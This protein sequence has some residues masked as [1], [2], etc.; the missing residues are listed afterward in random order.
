MDSHPHHAYPKLLTCVVPSG[1]ATS[2][3]DALFH[4]LGVRTANVHRGR[5][6]SHRS[7][8]FADE[9]EILTV[10]VPAD[11]ADRVFEFIYAQAAIGE[12]PHRFLFQA[13]LDLATVFLLPD[14]VDEEAG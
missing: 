4:Q 2:I 13:P 14:A 9:V 3:V 10:V 11:E 8:T 1:S 12:Q 5:G 6:A 7:G